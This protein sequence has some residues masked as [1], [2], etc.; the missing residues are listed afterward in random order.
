MHPAIG[1]FDTMTSTGKAPALTGIAL[2]TVLIS[3][4]F[5]P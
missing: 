3:T 2:A 4:G 5:T 1:G